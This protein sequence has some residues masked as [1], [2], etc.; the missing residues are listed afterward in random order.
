MYHVGS[1]RVRGFLSRTGYCFLA[2]VIVAGSG[3][4]GVVLTGA[5]PEVTGA[6][7]GSVGPGEGGLSGDEDTSGTRAVVGTSA[8]TSP[9]GATQHAQAVL[10]QDWALVDVGAAQ[11]DTCAVDH[12][13]A[14]L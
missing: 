5:F 2:G 14:S 4:A 10:P 11:C 8:G 9:A 6:G 12:H 3:A 1:N 7:L 13:P